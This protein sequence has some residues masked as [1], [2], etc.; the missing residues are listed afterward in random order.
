MLIRSVRYNL[1]QPSATPKSRRPIQKGRIA[2]AK[3]G[4]A[5]QQPSS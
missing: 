1:R 2:Q 4:K 3:S 5:K